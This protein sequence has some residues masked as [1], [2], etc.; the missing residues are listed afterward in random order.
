MND[1]NLND[2]E[3]DNEELLNIYDR[4][5]RRRADD[6]AA[7]QAALC[8]IFAALFFIAGL[9]YPEQT[10]LLLSHITELSESQHQLFPNPIAVIEGFF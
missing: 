9:I 3:R 8:I 4:P 5:V 7:M 2:Q 1:D 10:G 6:A